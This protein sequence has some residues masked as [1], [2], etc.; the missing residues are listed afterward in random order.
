MQSRF[1]IERTT[2][3]LMMLVVPLAVVGIAGSPGVGSGEPY[4]S[5]DFP[6]F[7][8]HLN[9]HARSLGFMFAAGAAMIAASVL[10]YSTFR[11]HGVRL[12]T[13][14]AG[15]LFAA[16]VL[17]VASAVAGV[18]LHALAEVWRDGGVAG[19]ATWLASKAT[20]EYV[21]TFS[22]LAIFAIAVSFVT[23]GALIARGTPPPRWVGVLGLVGAGAVLVA[24]PGIA[25]QVEAFWM[26]M[27]LGLLVV[28]ISFVVTGGWLLVR[29]TRPPAGPGGTAEA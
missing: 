10:L 29:G 19:D 8:R 21:S 24:M 15:A 1:M 12:A 22:F 16:G 26:L 27:M 2:G 3:A 5:E 14:G 13:A 23:V 25:A 11:H 7:V 20:V 28:L 6:T 18:R 4:F 9:E 17:F